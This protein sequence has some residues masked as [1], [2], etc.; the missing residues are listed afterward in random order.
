MRK[1]LINLILLLIRKDG[2]DMM[3]KLWVIEII[4][5]ETVEEAKIVYNKVPR[6]LKEKV[7][8]ILIESGMKE[9]I[10]E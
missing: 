7:K 2:I 5:Q 10:E 6:L 8:G 4:N 1:L 9:L 3:A